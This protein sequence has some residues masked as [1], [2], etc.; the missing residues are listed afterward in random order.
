MK[1]IIILISILFLAGCSGSNYENPST[2]I[3]EKI[4]LSKNLAYLNYEPNFAKD[5]LIIDCVNNNGEI[6]RYEYDKSKGTITTKNNF[7]T[8][9]LEVIK[10]E[11]VKN[12]LSSYVRLNPDDNALWVKHDWNKKEYFFGWYCYEEQRA[13]VKE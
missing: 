10:T 3:G 6:E 7:I 11:H 4:C 5:E 9:K 13:G 8:E 1:A 2:I 12:Q